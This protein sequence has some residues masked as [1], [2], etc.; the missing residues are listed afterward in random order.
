MAVFSVKQIL[1]GVAKVGDSVT[2]RGWVRNRRDSK[3]GLS[4]VTVS[5]GSCF[6]AIQVIAENKLTN[7]NSEIVNLTKDC[8]VIATGK[9]VE[10]QGGGQS[11]EII[12]DSIEVTGFVENPDTYPVSPKRHTVE[13]LREH[14][15]L[16]IRTNLISSVMRIRNTASVAIH[17]YLQANGFYWVHTP[18]ITASDCEGA[19]EL[20]KV[21]TLDFDKLPRDDK[22]KVDYK[23]DFFGKESFLTVSG[24]LNVE[25]YCMGLSK[26]YT[27]GP[28]FRAENSNTTR[29]L[30]EFWMVEP[31]MAFADLNDNMAVAQGMLKHVFKA[32]LDKNGDDM[33]FFAQFIDKS[34]ATRLEKMVND[35]FE[36]VTYT[37]AIARLEKSGRKFENP[38]YWGV[39]LASEHE[40]FLCEELVGKPT[41]VTNYPKEIKAFYMRQN[42][43]GKTVAAMDILAPGVGEI[44]GGAA[45]EERYDV[46]VGKMQALGMDPA[47][48]D[49]YLD[50]RRFGTAPHAGFGLGLERAVSYITGVQN[51]RDI[52]PFPRTPKNVAF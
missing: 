47:S 3:A 7:Y 30:A 5:D 45:R 6:D 14:A 26:V 46:L 11:V 38:L 37:D 41:I 17:D 52:I 15:H 8:A 33:A 29:H 1:A 13:Y 9:L 18:L 42:E 16:R 31:E 35:D 2:V 22:G 21:T 51:V 23:Q 48:L 50:L 4:F 20:F 40:R 34:V 44:V 12:A 24:Q 28:T 36:V 39:D 19:G 10:S 27:F 43:D 32:V 25:T 49:W